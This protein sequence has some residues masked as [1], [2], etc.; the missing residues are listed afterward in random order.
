MSTFISVKCMISKNFDNLTSETK[1]R[2]I[3]DGH[4]LFG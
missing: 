4:D 1:N 3:V 2:K